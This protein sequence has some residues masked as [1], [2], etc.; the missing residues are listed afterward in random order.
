MTCAV[1]TFNYP[2][3]LAQYPEFGSVTAGQAQGYFNRA[4]LVCDNTPSSPIRDLCERTILLNL[5]TAHVA[6]LFA[7]ANGQLANPIVGRIANAS[8]GS[9]SVG[10][11]YTTPS[12]DLEAWWDQTPYGAFFWASTTRYRTGFYVPPV[13]SGA[14]FRRGF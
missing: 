11:V 8:E 14:R 5:A 10:T 2:E 9:V 3:W 6:K 1:V 13:R 12:T 7:L 4:T